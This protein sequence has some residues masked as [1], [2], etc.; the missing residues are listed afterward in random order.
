[1][2]FS[3]IFYYE[4]LSLSYPKGAPVP[5]P[6]ASHTYGLTLQWM[7]NTMIDGKK[8]KFSY[9]IIKLILPITQF[10]FFT[11]GTISYT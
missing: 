1:M 2:R 8:I 7:S 10:H 4:S 11:S 5:N 6:L 9:T 3:S